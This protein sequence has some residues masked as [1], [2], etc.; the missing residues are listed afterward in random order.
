MSKEKSYDKIEKE[1]KADE[2][3]KE[4]Q[5]MEAL[6]LYKE[7][8][9]IYKQKNTLEAL[10]MVSRNIARISYLIWERNQAFSFLSKAEKHYT[11]LGEKIELAKVLGNLGSY[12]ANNQEYKRS[13]QYLERSLELFKENH[14]KEGIA[15]GSL[16]LALAEFHNKNDDNALKLLE[17]A[18]NYEETFENSDA[19]DFFYTLLA[20]CDY[21]Q[22]NLDRAVDNFSKALDFAEK[23]GDKVSVAGILI[24]IST[25]YLKKKEKE[26][27]EE[28][29]QKV[30][31]IYNTFDTKIPLADFYYLLVRNYII[32]GNIKEINN[33][34]KKCY[35]IFEEQENERGMA[36]ILREMAFEDGFMGKSDDLINKIKR[37]NDLLKKNE[38]FLEL[39]RN[40]NLLIKTYYDLSNLKEM[41][42]QIENAEK[43]IKLYENE[44]LTAQTLTKLAK[45]LSQIENYEEAIEKYEESL[46]IYQNLSDN[47]HIVSTLLD[48]GRMAFLMKEFNKSLK[49]NEEALE[50]SKKADY[51][52]GIADSLMAI[53]SD[54][55]SL[56]DY[57]K[58]HESLQ[59][60][61]EKCKE[62]K[63]EEGIIL[64]LKKMS[65]YYV[66]RED[67]D[68]AIANLEEILSI[69][70]DNGDI[71]GVITALFNIGGSYESK[72]DKDQALSHYKRALML[73]KRTQNPLELKI[74]SIIDNLQKELKPPPDYYS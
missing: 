29:K 11:D 22:F 55:F 50:V 19:A 60:A 24:Q 32:L 31:D 73:C 17:T 48:L 39:S 56:K 58:A 40:T 44:F 3:L 12:Y 26:K 25:I 13:L 54:Y 45:F 20:E 14:Y 7:S 52:I 1:L 63:D 47:K 59:L 57:D 9:N 71:Q 23:I 5:L 21:V 64:A 4:G 49:Y 67:F 27:F 69:Y 65:G 46:Q 28:Y 42:I 33:L 70:E 74:K 35:E 66:L 30:E 37:S 15:I 61:L 16:M 8:Y 68:N 6:K 72:G 18:K 53:G 38:D 34:L 51:H 62:K 10:A 41:Q 36:V 2:I 43:Y